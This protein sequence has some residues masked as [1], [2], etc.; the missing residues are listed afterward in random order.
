M[1]VP[2][3][4]ERRRVLPV[5]RA[6][7]ELGV[8]VSIDTS[9]PEL[10]RESIAEGA[11]MINDISALRAPGAMEAIA[12]TDAGV[13]LMHMQGT[14]MD[15]Q[16]APAYADVVAEVSAFLCERA[17]KLRDLG[18]DGARIV[19]DP[20]FGFGKSDEH[21]LI[22]LNGLA[23]IASHGYAIL[24]GLSRKSQLGRM[25]GRRDPR[26]RIGASIAAALAA[27]RNGAS[28]VRVH[29]VAETRDA[30]VVWQSIESARQKGVR[31]R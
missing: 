9:K 25:T 17:G 19:L 1:P 14:P 31:T 30:L 10:M 3:D 16:Q 21:N 20:G 29:D 2:L 18:V 24:A 26:H 28:I 5:V 4:E 6:V 13:C 23:S 22:L 8:P 12:Q 15:M 27:V 11:S 7:R